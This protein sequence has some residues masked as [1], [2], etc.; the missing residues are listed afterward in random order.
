M[1]LP[2]AQPAAGDQCRGPVVS[3]ARVR[4]MGSQ[5]R[6]IRVYLEIQINRKISIESPQD[7]SRRL[8]VEHRSFSASPVALKN[9]VRSERNL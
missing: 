5:G 1:T 2:E 3:T 4:S 8:S 9:S 6:M 7:R